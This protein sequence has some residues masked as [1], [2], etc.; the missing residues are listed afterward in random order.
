M[1]KEGVGL[2]FALVMPGAWLEPA[3]F[4]QKTKFISKMKERGRKM[5]KGTNKFWKG[6]ALLLVLCM[7]PT[8]AFAEGEEPAT[9]VIVEAV[10]ETVENS[11]AVTVTASIAAEGDITILALRSKTPMALEGSKLADA[12]AKGDIPELVESEDA[13][14]RTLKNS[15][16][17]ID[18]ET[19]VLN[20]ETNKYEVEFSFIPRSNGV[21]ARGGYI[22]IF[23]GGDTVEDVAVITVANLERAPKLGTMPWFSGESLTFDVTNTATGTAMDGEKRA[24]WVEGAT[25]T[26]TFA[27]ES[28]KEITLTAADVAE[29][30]NEDTSKS[31]I[32]TLKKVEEEA[33][34][35]QGKEITSVSITDANSE[36]DVAVWP[37]KDE[38]G[39]LKQE[40]KPAGVITA[41]PAKIAAGIATPI[42]ISNEDTTWGATWKELLEADGDGVEVKIGTTDVAHSYSAATGEFTITA[43]E[44][45]KGYLTVKVP[46]YKDTEYKTAEIEVISAPAYAADVILKA[47]VDKLTAKNVDEPTPDNF[48]TPAE[49]D[50]PP[51]AVKKDQMFGKRYVDISGL[52]AVG[53]DYGTVV[54]AWTD[55]YVGDEPIEYVDLGDGK[56]ELP[57]SETTDVTYTLTGTVEK[58]GVTATVT[59]HFTVSQIGVAGVDVEITLGGSI[60][61]AAKGAKITLEKNGVEA[62]ELEAL[63]DF[64]YNPTTPGNWK[65]K[66]QNV[67]E[68]DYTLVITRPGYLRYEKAVHIGSVAVV[69]EAPA[70]T[71]LVWG[72]ITSGSFGPEGD[73]LIDTSDYTMLCY[74]IKGLVDYD[75]KF[76]YD[77]SGVVDTTD[78]TMFC[79][80][81]KLENDMITID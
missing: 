70:Q 79:F 30:T 33:D 15:V 75:V 20:A 65:F 58:D 17:Y 37:A 81:L 76:D 36:F 24:L 48:Y 54:W 77:G 61:G 35:L 23:F 1:R 29:V 59:K 12:T 56:Y 40:G 44:L 51:E 46:N 52:P 55:D 11:E 47:E 60:A 68:G 14:V 39:T 78:Y 57:R 21:T 43:T 3:K 8:V 19:A 41:A 49:G 63:E 13:A 69:L 66:A 31:Y 16:V 71:D 50:Y 6:L 45:V 34:V 5:F 53:A 27:D 32:L 4:S 74:A 42:T 18:Q 80:F 28:A 22:N 67:T 72:D 26:V 25:A 9:K 10:N 7:L 2:N 38:T 73:T 64:D 62:F